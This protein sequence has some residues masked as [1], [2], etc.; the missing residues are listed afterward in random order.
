[1]GLIITEAQ[2]KDAQFERNPHGAIL[3]DGQE[4]A[5]TLQC[6]H[7]GSH[8]ISRKGSGKIRGWCTRC[9]GPVCGPSCAVCTPFEKK[10]EM[11][12]QHG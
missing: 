5:H 8:F 1:M 6:V 2:F 9:N 11:M 12:E 10:L 7:C 3:I 4:V